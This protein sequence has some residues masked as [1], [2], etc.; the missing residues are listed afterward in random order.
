MKLLFERTLILSERI[1]DLNFWEG[2][3][4]IAGILT[5]KLLRNLYLVICYRTH[6]NQIF[7]LGMWGLI[8]DI[9]CYQLRFRLPG[10]TR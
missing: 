9:V 5:I 4:V 2:N 8:P 7:D 6:K 3:K 1:W 10:M